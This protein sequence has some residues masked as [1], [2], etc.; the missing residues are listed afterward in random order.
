MYINAQKLQ[1]RWH[2]IYQATA[3]L[4]DMVYQVRHLA[5]NNLVSLQASRL[6]LYCDGFL[7]Q[8]DEL[9]DHTMHDQWEYYVDAII[10]IR[11]L[12]KS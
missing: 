5:T 6:L 2:G 3:A 7:N 11:L 4:N 8:T 12:T 1:S 9:H 10:D